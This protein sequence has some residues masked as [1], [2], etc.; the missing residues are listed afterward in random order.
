MVGMSATAKRL[1]ILAVLY[2]AWLAMMA[3]HEGGHV[4]HAVISGGRVARVTVPLL[5]FSYTELSS[6]PSPGF[7]AWGGPVWG[8][9]VPLGAWLLARR[10]VRR[11]A[12]AFQ[13]FAG[14]CLIANGVYIAAGTPEAIG[15]AETLLRT[16]SPAALLYACGTAAAVGGLYLWHTNAEVRSRRRLQSPGMQ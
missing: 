2:P 5:G 13:L 4:L 1:T 7:V 3:L 15:D 12:F 6:N 14:F 8:S 10:F 16:G 11:G 9:L